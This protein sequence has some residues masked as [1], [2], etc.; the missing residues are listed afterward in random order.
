VITNG[1][2]STVDIRSEPSIDW[3]LEQIVWPKGIKFADEDYK[4]KL[5]LIIIIF[6][7]LF[8][9]ITVSLVLTIDV[10]VII[11]LKNKLYYENLYLSVMWSFYI[12]KQIISKVVF[13]LQFIY[14]SK[15]KTILKEWV[16]LSIHRKLLNNLL[17]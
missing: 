10:F 16:R 3:G 12:K 14:N 7:A 13:D 6:N 11:D 9:I 4:L 2:I 17:N 1:I 15:F 5:I 8:L